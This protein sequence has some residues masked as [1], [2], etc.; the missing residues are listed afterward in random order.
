M[1]QDIDSDCTSEITTDEELIRGEEEETDSLS[2]SSDTE[3]NVHVTIVEVPTMECLH[4]LM[5]AP[6]T[7]GRVLY[8]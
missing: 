2:L 4:D 7:L 6:V 1:Y 3:Q 5:A 8:T